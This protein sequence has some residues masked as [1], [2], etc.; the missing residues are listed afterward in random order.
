MGPLRA[1]ELGSPIGSGA[2]DRVTAFSS[3]WGQC[4]ELAA[5]QNQ[6]CKVRAVEQSKRT[7]AGQ[8]RRATV[9]HML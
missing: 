6:G 8:A 7:D 5:S 3:A 4:F 9:P 1:Q 2:E